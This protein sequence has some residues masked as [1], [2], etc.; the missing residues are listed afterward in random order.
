MRADAHIKGKFIC[1]LGILHHILGTIGSW[2]DGPIVAK[3]K[4]LQQMYQKIISDDEVRRQVEEIDQVY[5]LKYLWEY[6]EARAGKLSR[7]NVHYIDV[8]HHI[9]WKCDGCDVPSL[10]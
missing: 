9:L 7:E 2:Y 3:M 5:P 4:V 10:F 1:D 6:V 8:F